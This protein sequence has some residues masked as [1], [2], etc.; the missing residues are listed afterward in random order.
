VSYLDSIS[1]DSIIPRE[2]IKEFIKSSKFDM[3]WLPTEFQ[4]WWER[5]IYLKYREKS[6]Y[7]ARQEQIELQDQINKDF[8]KRLTLDTINKFYIPRNLEEC[9]VQLDTILPEKNRKEYKNLKSKDEVI[10]NYHFGLGMY[11]RNNWGLWGGSRLQTYFMD[12]GEINP[13]GMSSVILEYYYD[14]LNGNKDCWKKWEA[15]NPVKKIK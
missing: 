8:A 14:W 1:T 3:R 11:L 13:E 9:F 2:K 10:G 4:C 6:K 15:E 12:R 7:K 5:E